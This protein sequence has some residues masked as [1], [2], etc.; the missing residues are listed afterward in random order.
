[1]VF[2]PAHW[3]AVRSGVADTPTVPEPDVAA[4]TGIDLPALSDPEFDLALERARGRLESVVT[5]G[6]TPIPVLARACPILVQLDAVQQYRADIARVSHIADLDAFNDLVRRLDRFDAD[7]LFDAGASEMCSSMGFDRTLFSVVSEAVWRP[8]V[9]FLDPAADTDT[10]ELRSFIANATWRLD[11]APLES[12]VVRRRRPELVQ[13]AQESTRTYKPLMRMS[14]SHSYVVAPIWVRRRVVGLLHADRWGEPITPE[15]LARVEAYA[16]C[17]GVAVE[18]ALLRRRLGELAR[19]CGELLSSAAA[20]LAAFECES[21]AL[22]VSWRAGESLPQSAAAR[23][24]AMAGGAASPENDAGGALATLSPREA[25][26]LVEMAHGQTNAEIAARLCLGEGT[27]KS[28]A[29]SLM[30]K[31]E[32]P[33]RA[34]AAAYLRRCRDGFD[35]RLRP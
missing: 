23:P 21:E 31:L 2:E 11:S 8:K 5:D 35:I 29:K 19:D 14:Q 6:S 4:L 9:L 27:V 28:Y 13:R 30:R 12:E 33:S 26:V 32:V 10:T 17:F 15:D 18:K 16:Q 22:P 7:D 25:D 34:A 20:H 3:P 1:M 24:F